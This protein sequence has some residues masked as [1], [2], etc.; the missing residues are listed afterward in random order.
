VN[1]VRGYKFAAIPEWILYHPKLTG[2]DIR[3]FGVLARFG[4]DVRPAQG[5]VADRI[6]KSAD[7]VKRSLHRLVEA[8]AV[9][10]E[11]RY[12]DGAQ[13]PN[14]YHLAGDEP[15]RSAPPGC[16]DAPTPGASVPPEREQDNEI[17]SPTETAADAKARLNVAAKAVVNVYWDAVKAETGKPPV[18][19]NHPALVKMVEAFLPHYDGAAITAALT[20]MRQR[21]RAMTRQV[22]EEHLDGRADAKGSVIRPDWKERARQRRAVGG[23]QT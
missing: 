10:V 5:T 22:L 20:T 4:D 18:G 1:I 19:V 7:T 21:C 8:G 3:V 12:K 17:P 14:R 23:T 9:F 11:A 13:L 6:G 16:M 15:I 2:E